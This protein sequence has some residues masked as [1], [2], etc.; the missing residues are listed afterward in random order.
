[1]ENQPPE[2]RP[3]DYLS[4]EQ[5]ARQRRL[6]ALRQD[7]AS[8]AENEQGATAAPVAPE[9]V[10]GQGAAEHKEPTSDAEKLN[11]F[12]KEMS[13]RRKNRKHQLQIIQDFLDNPV[14]FG[15][16]VDYI[17]H[18]TPLSELRQRRRELHYRIALLRSVLEAFEGEMSLIEQAE[19]SALSPDPEGDSA[20]ARSQGELRPTMGSDAAAVEGED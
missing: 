2:A 8:R 1:V 7:V 10:A 14:E 5:K 11:A 15:V 16:E 19:L 3:S 9:S 20:A 6:L 13:E 18:G 12:L 17:P 4:E